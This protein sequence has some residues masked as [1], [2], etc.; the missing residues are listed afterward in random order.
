MKGSGIDSIV[1]LYLEYIF[2]FQKE[3]I[4]ELLVR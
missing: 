3:R 2:T 4:T 1:L